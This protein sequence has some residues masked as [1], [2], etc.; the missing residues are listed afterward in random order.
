MQLLTWRL[1]AVQI[2]ENSNHFMYDTRS[3]H[4]RDYCVRFCQVISPL[5]FNNSFFP[6]RNASAFR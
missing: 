3:I 1:N 4:F 2:V 6:K 5:L